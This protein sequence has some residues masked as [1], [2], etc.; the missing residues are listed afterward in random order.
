MSAPAVEGVAISVR[1]DLEADRVMYQFGD[2]TF[3]LSVEDAAILANHSVAA[4]E[5]LRPPAAPGFVQ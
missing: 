1:A 4:I 5:I 2:Q 3:G